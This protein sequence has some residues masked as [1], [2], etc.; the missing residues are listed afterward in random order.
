M[1]KYLG[2]LGPRNT[3]KSHH[4]RPHERDLLG[5]GTKWPPLS[6]DR[7]SLRPGHDGWFYRQG[8]EW[9]LEVGVMEHAHRDHTMM[10]TVETWLIGH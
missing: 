4:S 5:A 2:L 8:S 9:R 6:S 10:V 3:T 1:K 7:E